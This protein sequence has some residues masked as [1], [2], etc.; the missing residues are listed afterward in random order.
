MKK[1]LFSLV[2]IGV[3]CIIGVSI[4]SA[5]DSKTIYIDENEQFISEYVA[6]ISSCRGDVKEAPDAGT[7]GYEDWIFAGWYKDAECTKR[8][9]LQDDVKSGAAWAK[10]VSPDVLTVKCQ[11][12]DDVQD[13]GVTKTNMRLVSSVDSL[14]YANVGFEIQFK[15]DGKVIKHS[16]TTVYER[17]VASVKSGVDFEYNPKVIDADSS[18]FVTATLMN[19][20]SKYYDEIF[21]IKPYWE[22]LD[23][24][25]VYGESRYVKVSDSYSDVV[26]VPVKVV[27]SSKL[28]S[29]SVEGENV[30]E[31]RYFEGEN[32]ASFMVNV[33]DVLALPS[34]SQYQLSDGS[35]VQYRNLHTRY[36]GTNGD[37]TWYQNDGSKDKY[38]IVTL[39]DLYGFANLVNSGNAFAGKTVYLGADI[40]VNQG[41]ARDNV[42]KPIGSSESVCF[43]GTFDGYFDTIE[44]IYVNTTEAYAG[45][46][47]YVE[48][49]GTITNLQIANSYYA[50]SGSSA[51]ALGSVVGYLRGNASKLYA[52]SD[53]EVHSARTKAAAGGYATGGVIGVFERDG[54]TTA[55]TI[56]ECW[57]EGK[58]SSTRDFAS[59]ILGQAY[60]G[61]LNLEDCLNTGTIT[62]T[63]ENGYVYA[64][65]LLGGARSWNGATGLYL[66]MSN[67]LNTGSVSVKHI[68]GV[69]SVVGRSL[70]STVTVKNVYT[71]DD[72]TNVDNETIQIDGTITGFGDYSVTAGVVY[73]IPVEV[74][75]KEIYGKDG[76]VSLDLDYYNS[77]T[78]AG[79]WAAIDGKIPELK[80]FTNQKV[81]ED[82]SDSERELTGWYYN[83]FRH[84][85]SKYTEA[86][87]TAWYPVLN[88][89]TNYEISSADELRGLRKLVNE[90]ID[91]FGDLV[92]EKPAKTI[93]GR[94]VKLTNNITMYE[95]SAK[96]WA[97]GKNLP[98]HTWSPIGKN[99]ESEKFAG[100][101]DGQGYSI[102]GVYATDTKKVAGE[103]NYLGLFA[104]T[105][106]SS[107]I[108]NVRMTNSYF[109]QKVTDGFVGSVACDIQ[110][111]ADTI[112]SD[113][114]IDSYGQQVGGIAARMNG[115]EY[116]V[117]GAE[118]T[119]DLLMGRGSMTMKNCWFDGKIR[120]KSITASTN[121]VGGLA[122]VLVQGTGHVN[123]SL[124]TGKIESIASEKTVYVGGL[125]GSAMAQSSIGYQAGSESVLNISSAI[126]AGEIIAPSGYRGAAV[127]RVLNGI[128]GGAANNTY[129]NLEDVFVTRECWQQARNVKSDLTSGGVTAQAVVSGTAIQTYETDRLIGYCTE[130]NTNDS[131]DFESTWSM[132]KS[133]VPILKS[134]ED[135][136]AKSDV[137]DVSTL[138]KEIGLDYWNGTLASAVNYGVG[139]YVASY[140][141]TDAKYTGYLTK[142]ESLGFVKYVDNSASTMDD[143]GI[144]NVIYT[145]DSGDWVLNITYVK[146]EAKI[147][148]SIS[149]IGKEKLA[150][151]LISAKQEGTNNVMFSMVQLASSGYGNGFVFQLPNGHFIVIDGGA[152]SD[153]PNLISY[154]RSLAGGG[155]VYIDAWVISHFHGDHSAAFNK[156]PSNASMRENVYL[157]AVYANESSNYS[158]SKDGGLN[159][160]TMDNAY[161]AAMSLT[162]A[163]GSKPDVHRMHMGERFYFNG[164][165]MDVIQALEQLPVD[166]YNDYSD[167]DQ[168]NA[169]STNC[170]FT[171]NATGDKILT[172]GD[173]T[174]VNMNYIMKAYDGITATAKRY[175]AD[176]RGWYTDTDPAEITKTKTKTLSDISVFVA[177]HHGKNTTNAFTRYLVGETDDEYT[178]DVVFFPFPQMMNPTLYET[179][180]YNGITYKNRYWMEDN[181][182]VF[183][184]KMEEVNEKLCANVTVGFYTYGYEDSITNSS[185]SNQHG[186]V[187][188]YFEQDGIKVDTLQSWKNG[189]GMETFK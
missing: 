91:D 64:A 37:K 126:S 51:K 35:T 68:Y 14:N 136:V 84:S 48:K 7:A 53:V 10:Y 36:D 67:C 9:A 150:S 144:Y 137:V 88:T 112:Y 103:F 147:Y 164:V 94:C 56:S 142:L 75:A 128:S 63:Y 70:Q 178:F 30:G 111:V 80:V 59:G 57:F 83:A 28:S 120:I 96:D 76:Y 45:L 4:A 32:Y 20:Q 90:G 138:T 113:A 81:I 157:E 101:F 175:K 11:V 146:N 140:S 167:P 124:F 163:D 87:G 78:K 154:L 29:I 105:A 182:C 108:K 86:D 159:I 73:G 132:R 129:L 43:N 125:V 23:G 186:T 117:S 187:Q 109:K 158:K 152:S 2:A 141:A 85:C 19:I 58:V 172:G 12:K 145:K 66:N 134:F 169:T 130:E 93:S 118:E 119:G 184:Y 100:T 135:M 47:G 5:E 176:D 143:D 69:G 156:L 162:K 165:T 168:F 15:E 181:S 123:D 38:V 8:N 180:I 26:S 33:D 171:I 82:F 21:M 166:S 160:T 177:Y 39:A 151:N 60:R 179:Y 155:P 24:T 98:S 115:L 185:A 106:P 121:F 46:F 65:G 148:I 131:L 183:N 40:T 92:Y 133:G 122:G 74:D 173:S 44:G 72:V 54:E 6:D 31:R 170:M 13:E 79:V 97:E 42:W 95:G 77:T 89:Q 61:T 110:G 52:G 71:T 99:D 107:T 189:F 3:L 16:A 161:L 174:K 41:T 18:Y 102:S 139:N 104:I 22:T 116:V 153:G 1:R 149:T 17:I 127:G 62:S 49:N 188:L 114:I 50:N 55:G 27:D 25:I 34:L